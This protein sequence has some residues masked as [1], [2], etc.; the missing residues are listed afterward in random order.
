MFKNLK[1]GSAW[2]KKKKKKVVLPGKD[3]SLYSLKQA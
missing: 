3:Y 2:G 1:T